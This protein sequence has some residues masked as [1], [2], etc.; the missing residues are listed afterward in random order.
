MRCKV[1]ALDH[2]LQDTKHEKGALGERQVD[3]HQE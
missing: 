3:S 1:T 2:E